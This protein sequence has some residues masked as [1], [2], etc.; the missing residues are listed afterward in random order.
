LVISLA[1]W[2]LVSAARRLEKKAETVLYGRSEK[3]I[4]NEVPGCSAK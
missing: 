3:Q 4:L 1:L 2:R